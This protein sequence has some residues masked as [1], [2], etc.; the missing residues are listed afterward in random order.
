MCHN[1]DGSDSSTDKYTSIKRYYGTCNK[2]RYYFLSLWN[3][4]ATLFAREYAGTLEL[5]EILFRYPILLD[6]IRRVS[7]ES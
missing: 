2:R 6:K 4:D 3:G 5:L 1:L 7:S